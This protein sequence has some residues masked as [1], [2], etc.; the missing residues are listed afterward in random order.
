MSPF[1]L[2]GKGGAVPAPDGGL[3]CGLPIIR[4]ACTASFENLG[5]A[6]H[7]SLRPTFPLKGEGEK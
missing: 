2:Q 1:T 7:P 6:P 4:L 3:R 5:A